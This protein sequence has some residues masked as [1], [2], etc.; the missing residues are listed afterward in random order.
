MRRP[1][2]RS[3]TQELVATAKQ[4][5]PGRPSPKAVKAGAIAVGGIVGAAAG[6]AGISSLRRRG[7]Q[8][9]RDS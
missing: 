1:F 3:R 7:E 2:K 9:A 5:V 8:P 6:S 4:A